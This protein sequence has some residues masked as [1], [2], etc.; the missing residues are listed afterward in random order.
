MFWASI[1]RSSIGA[2][3]FCLVFCVTLALAQSGTT[4]KIRTW[5]CLQL[6]RKHTQRD[7]VF[8]LILLSWR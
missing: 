4:H 3:I 8:G 6:H 1:R 7:S 2:I 5:A